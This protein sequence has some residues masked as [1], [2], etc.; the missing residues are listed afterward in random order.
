MFNPYLS[1]PSQALARIPPRKEKDGPLRLLERL[2]KLDSDDL[3]LM[4][5]IYLLMK[6]PDKDE[7]WPLLAALVYC[8][9]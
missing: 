2:K 7:L 1:A 3:L 5:I 8:I 4:L 6:E 9:L